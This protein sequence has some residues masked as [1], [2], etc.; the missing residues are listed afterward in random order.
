MVEEKNKKI[1]VFEV[2]IEPYLYIA[3]Y[4]ASSE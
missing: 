1:K 2:Y 4:E 3:Y